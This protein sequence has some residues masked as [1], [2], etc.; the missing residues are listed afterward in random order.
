LWADPGSTHY[1][2]LSSSFPPT[3]PRHTLANLAYRGLTL[4]LAVLALTGQL[5]YLDVLYWNVAGLGALGEGD[6]Q[7]ALRSSVIT[8]AVVTVVV[9]AAGLFLAFRADGNRGARPF[10]LALAAWGYLLAYSGLT[11]LFAPAPESATRAPFDAHFLVVEALALAALL[12]FTA[13]FPVPLRREAIQDPATLH[14]LLRPLQ[15]VRGWLLSPVGP[16][17]AGA[18]A[19]ALILAANAGQGRP[20]QDAPLIVP[21]DA[22]RLTAL[23]VVVLNLRAAFMATDTEGRR[24]GFWFVVGFTLLLGAVGV[25]LGGNVLTAVT[26]WAI[27]GFNWRPVVL[28]LGVLGL[29]WGSYRGIAY[30]G[31]RK[32]GP[33]ARRA[34]VLAATVT[35]ALFLAAGL[36]SLLTGVVAT[37]VILPRGI[38]TLSAFVAM[39]ILYA[40]IRGPVESMLYH[41]WADAPEGVAER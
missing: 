14:L 39:G 24:A 12:R 26:Q 2:K 3:D 30:R 4:V 20:I 23:A 35:V 9:V 5:A 13:L 19:C 11:I 18:G 29:I 40:R 25:L 17:V 27:P 15:H 32:P 16:W 28:D 33:L 37:A 21:A 1:W 36:E 7:P 10:G 8:G 31:T 22:F 34:A 38:G 6:L 41:A